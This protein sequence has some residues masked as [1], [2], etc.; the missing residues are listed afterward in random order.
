VADD[1]TDVTSCDELKTAVAATKDEERGRQ[2]V[3]IKKSIELGC[4][5]HIPESWEVDIVE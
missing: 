1:D 5:E 3:L 2:R 4:V